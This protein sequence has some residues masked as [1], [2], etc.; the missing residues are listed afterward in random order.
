LNDIL[1]MIF[2]LILSGANNFNTMKSSMVRNS[3][4]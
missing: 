4:I 3:S 1:K 2:F